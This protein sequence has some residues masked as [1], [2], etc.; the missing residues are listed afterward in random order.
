MD[1]AEL[2]DLELSPAEAR[3]LQ[4]ELAPGV[5]QGPPLSLDQ[6]RYVA[7]ADVSTNE[8]AG[9][10]AVTVVSLPDLSVVEV[11]GAEA[12]LAFFTFRGCWHSGRYRPWPRL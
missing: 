5:R 9:Y 1:L 2:H 7:G 3:K 8:D 6:V 12:E 11:Q 10:A 4:D